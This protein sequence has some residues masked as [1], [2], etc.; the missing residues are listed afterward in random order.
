MTNMIQKFL[1]NESA[2]GIL[3]IGAAMVAML[4]ANSPASW[5]YDV[6]LAMP[7]EVRI[8]EFEIA[9]PLLL[10]V[11]DGL[12]VIFFLSVGLELKREIVEGELSDKK[13]IALPALGALGGML[14]PGVIY[15]FI[16]RHGRLG[17]SYRNR[18]R[19]FIRRTVAF[20]LTHTAWFKSIFNF[21]GH[22]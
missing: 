22:F 21:T 18:Y 4:L 15:A 11:N 8:G 9:K 5:L 19:F 6:L 20:R 1:Q 7:I 14:F 16:N 3:L 12:M 2:G 17:Y 10:W 13:N